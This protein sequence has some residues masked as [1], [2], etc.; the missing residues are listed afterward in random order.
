MA[1]FSEPGVIR[2]IIQNGG[3]EALLTDETFASPE[4][5]DVSNAAAP[6]CKYCLSRARVECMSRRLV[7]LKERHRVGRCRWK[8]WLLLLLLHWG[9]CCSCDLLVSDSAVL[10]KAYDEAS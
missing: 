2:R 7:E 10:V 1:Q 4:R 9:C 8:L 5:D 6:T 3:A